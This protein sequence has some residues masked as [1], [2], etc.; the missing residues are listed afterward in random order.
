MG[1]KWPLM[2][3]RQGPSPDMPARRSQ[4]AETMFGEFFQELAIR[5][6]SGILIAR[7]GWLRL[8]KNHKKND[9]FQII[10]RVIIEVRTQI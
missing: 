8:K 2:P 4:T 6:V 1:L 7:H 9:K 10:N 5:N 3:L